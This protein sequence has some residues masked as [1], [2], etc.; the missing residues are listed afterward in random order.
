MMTLRHFAY[1]LATLVTFAGNQMAM[2]EPVVV[3]EL[4]TSQGCSS[5]PP[6]DEYFSTLVG[7]ATV[8]PLAMHVDY[9]DYIG[10]KDT[11]SNPAFTARQHAYARAFGTRTVYTP[12][13]I[14]GG[15]DRIEGNNPAAMDALIRMHQEHDTGVS[16][17]VTR[18]GDTLAIAA[19]G[20]T[21]PVQV[22]IVRY[23]PEQS[24]AIKR[25][26]NAGLT[27]RY[28]NIVTA[29]DT[30]AEWSGNGPLQMEATIQGDEEVVVILQKA[31]PSKILAAARP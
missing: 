29:W 5:C 28:R 31:G 2:A 23:V 24:V 25:G 26:E 17:D 27:I 1:G 10:W 8:I 4:Y 14:V 3:V 15:S 7:K 20:A 13:M 11:F 22:M 18:N 12:Q 21:E 16:L 19:N 6:A 30:V 9:W